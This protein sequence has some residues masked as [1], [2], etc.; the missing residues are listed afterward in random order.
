L[1][2]VEGALRDRGIEMISV[3]MP[4]HSAVRARYAPGVHEAFI[5]AL[6]GKVVNLWSFLADDE[7]YDHAHPMASGR[8]RLTAEL[9]ELLGAP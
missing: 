3:V 9:K 6:P 4:E 1:K 5:A 7:L 2:W 8:E